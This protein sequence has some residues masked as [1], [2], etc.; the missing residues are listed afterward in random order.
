METVATAVSRT[1]LQGFFGFLVGVPFVLDI[2]ISTWEAAKGAGVT[3]V[4]ALLHAFVQDPE[5]RGARKT[6]EYLAAE[7]AHQPPWPP[8]GIKSGTIGSS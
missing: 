3:A 1:F 7:K 8:P 2:D 4:F 5:A 6:A